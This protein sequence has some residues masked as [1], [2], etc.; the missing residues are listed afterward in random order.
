MNYKKLKEFKV[1]EFITLR[2]EDSKTVIYVAGEKFQQCKFLLL[3]IA[4]ENLADFTDSESV[5]EA[6]ER[7]DYS[8]E[9]NQPYYEI[10][11]ETEFWGHC[12]NIQVWKEND[13]DT[14][15]L[16]SDL[17][18]PLLKKLV[19]V[20]DIK[21]ERVFK[22]EITLRL[23]SGYHNVIEYLFEQ[24]YIKYL[25]NKELWK[26]IIPSLGTLRRQ[27]YQVRLWVYSNELP[28][29]LL[30][31]LISLGD[32]VALKLLKEVVVDLLQTDDIT[33]A[34]MLYDGEYI[35]LLS[36]D[37]FWNVFGEDG[38]IL[39][40]FEAKIRQYKMITYKD[41]SGVSITKKRRKEKKEYCYFN[42]SNG[43][44][45]DGGPMVFTFENGH[46]TGIGVWSDD[47]SRIEVSHLPSE[48][49]QLKHLEELSL[50]SVNL[51]EVPLEISNLKNLKILS[52]SHN[53]ITE[54]PQEICRLEKLEYLGLGWN[55]LTLLPKCLR[56]LTLL[57][58]IYIFDNP[59]TKNTRSFLKE[60]KKERGFTIYLNS[61]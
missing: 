36:R 52:L 19:D 58:E 34:E 20:G 30:K 24:D 8:L 4:I 43:V 44:Y 54:L 35:N 61:I 2:L 53:L 56:K 21:A 26:V 48:M 18:F 31:R 9:Y 23:S 49:F 59:L 17:A 51:T 5:D 40:R 33:N 29:L 60:L 14:R 22:E 11:P 25:T 37:E 7:L 45:I 41:A 3:N 57:Q 28:L 47:R 1:N 13:Y 55:K 50:S 39:K 38:A 12:S 15:I 16:K 10:S 42:L 46:I 6:A 32:G 27:N